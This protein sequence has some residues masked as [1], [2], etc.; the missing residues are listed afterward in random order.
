[1]IEGFLAPSLCDELMKLAMPRLTRSKVWSTEKGQ[2]VEDS[3]RVSEQIFLGS[4]ETELVANI[5]RRIAEITRTPM[6]NGEGIQVVRYLSG[7]YYK[8][9]FDYFEPLLVT[10]K[11]VLDRGG[12]RI[13]TFMVYLND[14]AEGGSTNFPRIGFRA[15][16]KQGRAIY[17][18][19]VQPDGSVDPA[20]E[21]SAEA[22]IAG[23]KWIFTKWIR[24]RRFD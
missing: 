15:Q 11:A 13:L 18:S 5:E 4:Q 20:T 17:W 10:N 7:G 24:E 2:E 1:V 6:E 19:N 16:P 9:H 23:E 21:H 3:Y 8:A 12:Q 14:V 22:V